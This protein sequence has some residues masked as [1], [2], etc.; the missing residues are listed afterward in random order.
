MET[1]WLIPFHQSSACIRGGGGLHGSGHC[2]A[3]LVFRHITCG[4]RGS[5]VD[6]GCSRLDWYGFG[7]QD[8]EGDQEEDSYMNAKDDSGT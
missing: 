8:S 4:A 7:K 6:L 2:H 5:T 3:G 1:Y